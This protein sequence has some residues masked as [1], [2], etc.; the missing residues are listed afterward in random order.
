[1]LAAIDRYFRMLKWL[2]KR[3]PKLT[4]ERAAKCLKWAKERGDWATEEFEGV[5][6]SGACSAE[7]PD[8][9]HQVWVF[10]TPSE[11]WKTECIAPRKK[12][13]GVS[14]ML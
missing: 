13:K 7:K 11:K 9:A 8:D 2:A 6:W 4:P 1:M 5:I 10:K 12:G 14:A 3:R